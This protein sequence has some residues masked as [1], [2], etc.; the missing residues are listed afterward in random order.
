MRFTFSMS[1]VYQQGMRK[2]LS[3][4]YAAS[5][6]RLFS[7]LIGPRHSYISTVRGLYLARCLGSQLGL[8]ASNDGGPG[9]L[10]ARFV[11]MRDRIGELEQALDAAHSQRSSEA[12][13]LLSPGAL[14]IK[15]RSDAHGAADGRW[16][17]PRQSSEGTNSDGSQRPDG[18]SRDLLDVGYGSLLSFHSLI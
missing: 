3:N 6:L 10:Q 17:L 13:P 14:L 15:S 2:S 9:Q 1:L 18:F 5:S 4:W 7:K 11:Q 12:H 8:R 16:F